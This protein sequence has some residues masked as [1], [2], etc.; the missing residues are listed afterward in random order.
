MA[1]RWKG[2]V[3]V[4]IA[5]SASLAGAG[6]ALPGAGAEEQ[7][8]SLAAA[9]DFGINPKSEAV[10]SAMGTDELDFVLTTGDYAYTY[11]KPASEFC[12][13]VKS[14]IGERPIHLLVGNHDEGL[15][16]DADIRELS[17]CLPERLPGVVGEYG[18]EYYHDV[19]GLARFIYLSPGLERYGYRYQEGDIH[20][21][22]VSDVID[23]AR[24]AGIRWVVVST[25]F[26]C[27]SVGVYPCLGGA[28]LTNLLVSKRVDL[29]LQGHEHNYSRTKQLAHTADCVSISPGSFDADCIAA[30]GGIYSG[31]DG[32][33][34]AIS[35]A[36][37]RALRP[38]RT[39]DPEYPYFEAANGSGSSET[40]G[41]LR[42][43]V[44]Q[45]AL[46]GTFV[47]VSGRGLGKFEDSFVISLGGG[48]PG[49]ATTQPTI[50]S[51]STVV[52]STIAVTTSRPTGNGSVDVSASSPN[53]VSSPVSFDDADVMRTDGSG[54][55]H[56]FRGSENGFLGA[57]DIDA[58]EYRDG[59][60]YFSLLVRT[61]INGVQ[62]DDSDILVYREG[63]GVSLFLRGVDIGLTTGPEDVDALSFTP[64][65][66]LV[67]S[68]IGTAQTDAGVTDD[69]DL[70][71]VRSNRLELF[72]AGRTVG[73]E[74]ASEDI[75]GLS[76]TAD[77]TA[78]YLATAGR[79]KI[80]N[81]VVE[82]G[83][84]LELVLTGPSA[85]QYA[86]LSAWSAS[87]AG[88]DRGRIDGLSVN[89]LP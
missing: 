58:F 14:G 22:W 41:Y 29:V 55:V 5:L 89:S 47:P 13:F 69:S 4:I 27:L 50:T 75:V 45:A 17:K 1:N 44:T 34:F 59:A 46:S 72:L 78:A 73:L 77:G 62:Y 23:D 49:P 2:P 85:G 20:Y 36:G 66:E 6:L 81:E 24:S 40:Y 39:W 64:A 71:V 88:F 11:K 19:N 54:W 8:F 82:R 80:G 68:T 3:V 32:T 84:I 16:G 26:N 21:Q 70:L 48:A 63:E 74:R 12:D 52:P 15:G 43:D 86:S 61:R 28:D 67:L 51:P 56:R 87:S 7:S 42:L 33:I 83:D 38:I 30:S 79:A 37:G 76:I 9:G 60:L 53:S 65:G 18:V 35:G 25:H 31:G 57:A 10:F